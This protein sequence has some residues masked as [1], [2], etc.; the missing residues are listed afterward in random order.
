MEFHP[1]FNSFLIQKILYHIKNN[2][3]NICK[4]KKLHDKCA[5]EKI[6]VAII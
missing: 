2:C 1:N 6:G 5:N 3:Y 4:T